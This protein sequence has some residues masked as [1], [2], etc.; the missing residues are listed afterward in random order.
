MSEELKIKELEEENQLLLNQLFLA[1]AELAKYAR[2]NSEKIEIKGKAPHKSDPKEVDEQI[3]FI[4]EIL[5]IGD[6]SG[7]HANVKSLF[8]KLSKNKILSRLGGK[9]FVEI[10][11]VYNSQGI[12]GVDELLGSI[13]M[14]QNVRADALTELARSLRK[15]KKDEAAY[16]ALRAWQVDP[17]PYR[18]KWLIFRNYEAG[19]T[20]VAKIMLEALPPT[21][22]MSD[23]E[24]ETC[25]KIKNFKDDSKSYL[26]I[27]KRQNIDN[28]NNEVSRIKENNRKIIKN[29]QDDKRALLK[30]IDNITE[31]VERVREENRLLLEIIRKQLPEMA[32]IN[33][34]VFDTVL[35]QKRSI[36]EVVEN[37]VEK[38]INKTRA[39]D[40]I[41][42]YIYGKCSGENKLNSRNLS[43]KI[44][45]E[46]NSALIRGQA[47]DSLKNHFGKEEI[48]SLPVMEKDWKTGPDA[49]LW[50]SQLISKNEYDLIIEFGSG[51]STFFIAKNIDKLIMSGNNSSKHEF[52]SFEHQKNFYDKTMDFLKSENMNF[53]V[54]M[55]FTPL[56]SIEEYGNVIEF[57]SCSQK[58]KDMSI[59]FNNSAKKILI[60]IDGPYDNGEI[61]IN[62]PVNFI[63]SKFFDKPKIDFIINNLDKEA[64]TL[65]ELETACK[66]MGRNYNIVEKKLSNPIVLFRLNNKNY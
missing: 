49:L 57:Y 38:I 13:E 25:E 1:Q 65:I 14:P 56:E 19:K 55:Q 37:G 28:D 33:K 12:K 34:T 44:H 24:K 35:A 36:Q 8:W 23:S 41:H 2:E 21:I 7:F 46:I 29:W 5:K 43:D 32:N 47:Y 58:L 4:R 9:S 53:L 52:V 39:N 42:P 48:L 26:S 63:I 62:Y 18:L 6:E 61:N 17:K 3:K 45:T 51:I 16:F 15:S 20:Q 64:D 60:F 30:E 31:Q 54:D 50:L 40:K 59:N 10:I 66:I 27:V 11:K 22:K